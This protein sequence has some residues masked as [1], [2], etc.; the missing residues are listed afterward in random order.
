MAQRLETVLAAQREF[1]ANASHQLRTPLT[2]L[3]LRL[4]AARA[5]DGRDAAS[6]LEAA[7]LEVER[8][9]RLLTSLLTLAREG[10]KPPAARPV[11]L[12]RAAERGPRALGAAAEQDGRELELVGSGEATIAASE[13]DLA[14]LLD[15]LIENALRYSRRTSR[16][17]GVA[18]ARRPGWPCSTPGRARS[19]RGDGR[20]RPL[21]ARQRRQLTA[22]HRAR[23]RNR[24]DARAPLAGQRLAVEPARGRDARRGALSGRGYSARGVMGRTLVVAALALAGLLC[25]AGMGLAAYVVSRDS[26]AVP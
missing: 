22:G 10:D 4:E 21:R 5:K 1:V 15:N 14:I 23:P 13:E 19:R 11:S 17:T 7:E 25:A 3:R 26:V 12:A 24:A 9:A 18:T 2:G 16:S 8:L 6:E 20:V